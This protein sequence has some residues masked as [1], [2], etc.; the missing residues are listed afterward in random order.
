[1]RG[2]GTMTIDS[3]HGYSTASPGTGSMAATPG[4]CEIK[5]GVSQGT[6]IVES[7]SIIFENGDVLVDEAGNSFTF[8]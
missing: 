7:N 3:S 8:E 2:T 4:H 1:M 6:P 5:L